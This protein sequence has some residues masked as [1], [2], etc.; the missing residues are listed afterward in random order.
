[1]LD[2]IRNWFQASSI[3]PA[4]RESPIL[5]ALV[6]SYV[7]TLAE[8]SKTQEATVATKE[9]FSNV[10]IPAKNWTYSVGRPANEPEGFRWIPLEA[11]F[12]LKVC[13]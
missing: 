4:N 1:M 8:N 6:E 7:A 9:Y 5:W 13:L 3:G 10:G 2:W 12:G 11:G